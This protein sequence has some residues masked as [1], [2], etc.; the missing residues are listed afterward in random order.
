MICNVT[1]NFLNIGRRYKRSIPEQHLYFAVLV[2]DLLSI[3]T[4]FSSPYKTNSLFIEDKEF[5]TSLITTYIWRNNISSWLRMAF[6][7][8]QSSIH[9]WSSLLWLLWICMCILI[10]FVF[11]VIFVCLEYSYFILRRE[12]VW[13]PVASR[14]MKYM[15]VHGSISIQYFYPFTFLRISIMCIVCILICKLNHA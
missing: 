1:K 7:F 8:P 11:L 6:A 4:E 15:Y 9:L 13:Q 3:S 12:S 14:I 10:L 5:S 2:H